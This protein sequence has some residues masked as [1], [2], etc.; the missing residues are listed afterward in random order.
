MKKRIL[1][2]VIS[3]TFIIT[4]LTACGDKEEVSENVNPVVTES[5]EGA[6]E[7][8]ED[9]AE[10]VA[11]VASE[12]ITEE[13]QTIEQKNVELDA[14]LSDDATQSEMNIHSADAFTLWDDEL[15]SLW[16]RISDLADDD[17]KATLLDEQRDWIKMKEDQVTFA[18]AMFEGGTMQPLIENSTAMELTRVR[19]YELAV[20]LAKLTNQTFDLEVPEQPITAK[21]Y[22]KDTQGTGTDIY[23]DLAMTESYEGYDITMGLYRLTTLEGTASFSESHIYDYVDNNIDVEGKITVTGNTAKFEVTRSGIDL[24][25]AGDVFEFPERVLIGY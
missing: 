2:L 7:S 11:E 4:A 10:S 23:S 18:G 3:M 6:G 5:T 17:Y 12:I 22:F 24:F 8:V 1:S 25:N 21:M 19:C 13:I 20:V 9:K 16:S 15:N 14:S